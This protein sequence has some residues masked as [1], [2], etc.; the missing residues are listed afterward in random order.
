MKIWNTGTIACK[1]IFLFSFYLVSNGESLMFPA[2]GCI[3]TI[4][5]RSGCAIRAGAPCGYTIVVFLF[6]LGISRAFPR[7]CL[8][9]H[10]RRGEPKASG[11]IFF[12]PRSLY[13][14]K[15][16][17]LFHLFLTWLGTGEVGS[18]FLRVRPRSYIP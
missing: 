2:A 13:F 8:T 4:V 6:R 16:P 11:V 14:G 10:G 9:P 17:L 5:W 18:F 15:F 3:S 12:L 7:M 1:K